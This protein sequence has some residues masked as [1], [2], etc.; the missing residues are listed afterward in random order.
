MVKTGEVAKLARAMD[1]EEA[2]QRVNEMVVKYVEDHRDQ[3]DINLWEAAWQRIL[4]G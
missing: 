2:C 3:A 4:R 1:W